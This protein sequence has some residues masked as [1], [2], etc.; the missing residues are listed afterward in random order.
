MATL[1]E[2]KKE[3]VK[4]TFVFGKEN[5]KLFFIGLGL[6]IIG[7][8]L[9]LGGGS[10]NPEEFDGGALFSFRRITLAPFLVI[11]GYVVIIF[12]IMKNPDSKGLRNLFKSKHNS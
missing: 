6:V 12:S 11:L 2:S 7:F 5:F 9:M 3:Q 4:K 10:E 1:D 8:V